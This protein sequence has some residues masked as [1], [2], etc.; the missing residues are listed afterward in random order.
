MTGISLH[1][2][3]QFGSW[4]L[5]FEALVLRSG[6]SS[7]RRGAEGCGSGGTSAVQ[8]GGA[9]GVCKASLK[10]NGLSDLG[11]SKKLLSIAV[12]FLLAFQQDMA[13]LL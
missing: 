10:T 1:C 11:V 6:F 5:D 4:I 3:H 8:S 7:R 13:G 2:C 12:D 9:A